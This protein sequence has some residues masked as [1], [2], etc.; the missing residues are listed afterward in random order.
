MNDP[1]DRPEADGGDA[2]S[3]DQAAEAPSGSAA[4]PP[5]RPP[6]SRPTG[7]SRK[8]PP[9]QS[10]YDDDDDD[11][12]DAPPRRSRPAAQSRPAPPPQS[13]YD[14]EDDDDA[15]APRPQ[16]P[17]RP[18]RPAPLLERVRRDRTTLY[19]AVAALVVIA[20]LAILLV[21]KKSGGNNSAAPTTGA[22]TPQSGQGGTTTPKLCGNLPPELGGQ[23]GTAA[24][25]PPGVYIWNDFYNV[26]IRAK[27]GA[28]TIKV[29]GSAPVKVKDAPAAAAESKA[30]G[31]SFTDWAAAKSKGGSALVAG[32]VVTISVP[33]SSAPLG[34]NLDVSCDVK[35]MTVDV[36]SPAGPVPA[37][38][39][40]LGDSGK[41]ISNP[42]PINRETS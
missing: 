2:G 16:R 36:S 31:P 41:A 5:S 10:R 19:V 28:Y 12:D 40:H 20:V 30:Y 15:D 29:S 4:A 27:G 6:D 42:L 1:D 17:A 26:H 34:P 22:S 11:A 32:N 8:A 18:G 35:A 3:D 39:I 21:T 14:D 23:A 33:A 38:D 24:S 9:R 13:R 25:G 7:R 37:S